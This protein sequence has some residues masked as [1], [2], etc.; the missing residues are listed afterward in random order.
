MADGSIEMQSFLFKFTHLFSNGVNS[1]LNFA[2]SG[3]KM[4]VNLNVLIA[5]LPE[6]SVFFL[7]IRNHHRSDVE[8]EKKRLVA[9]MVSLLGHTF[10]NKNL[11]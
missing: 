10:L 11:K 1:N 3:G 5:S 6:S 4:Y 7:D 2:T 9:L 8:N